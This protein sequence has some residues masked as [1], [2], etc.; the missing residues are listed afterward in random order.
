MR[1]QNWGCG[2][3]FNKLKDITDTVIISLYLCMYVVYSSQIV[4]IKIRI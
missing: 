4:H 3:N 2:D 1:E